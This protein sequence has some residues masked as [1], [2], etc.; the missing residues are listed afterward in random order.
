MP[1]GPTLHSADVIHEH[2]DVH[3]NQNGAVIEDG[4]FP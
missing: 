3:G 1:F 2:R 4:D